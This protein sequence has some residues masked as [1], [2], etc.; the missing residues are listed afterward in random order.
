MYNFGNAQVQIENSTLCGALCIMC[1]CDKFKHKYSLANE[2][3][4]K[5]FER[6]TG[7]ILV[8]IPKDLKLVQDIMSKKIQDE[9][10][11][12]GITPPS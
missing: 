3:N 8:D 6:E 9:M 5:S 4:I 1:P 10:K 12:M 11:I 2:I 7:I